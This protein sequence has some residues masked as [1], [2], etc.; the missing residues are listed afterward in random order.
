MAE[1]LAGRLFDLIP[2]GMTI[3]EDDDELGCFA[4]RDLRWWM[5]A[6]GHDRK[7]TACCTTCGCCVTCTAQMFYGSMVASVIRE[8]DKLGA[9]CEPGEALRA[10]ESHE[11]TP[12]HPMTPDQP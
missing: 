12:G 3:W 7:H 11:R 2:D 6:L 4:D 1:S 9:L 10:A 5:K 8:L